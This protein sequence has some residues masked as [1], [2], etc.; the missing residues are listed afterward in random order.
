MDSRGNA[1]TRVPVSEMFVHP[2]FGDNLTLRWLLQAGPSAYK[3]EGTYLITSKQV[4][5]VWQVMKRVWC[6]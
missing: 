5:Q 3:Q 4:W 6:V 1:S 2:V